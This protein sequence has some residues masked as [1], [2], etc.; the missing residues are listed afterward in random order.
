MSDIGEE[1]LRHELHV[2]RDSLDRLMEERTQLTRE[3][4][5]ARAMVEEFRK[6]YAKAIERDDVTDL[7]AVEHLGN[8]IWNARADAKAAEFVLEQRVYAN[9]ACIE[10]RDEARAQ[11]DALRAHAKRLITERCGTQGHMRACADAATY[12]AGLEEEDD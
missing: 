10:Q 8:V 12:L 9:D 6:I 2:A 4:D 1:V 11:R 7:E 5:E 3:R